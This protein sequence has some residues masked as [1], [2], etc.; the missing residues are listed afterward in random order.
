M[1]LAR[2]H[3]DDPTCKNGAPRRVAA[4]ANKNETTW[5]W[6]VEKEG[7]IGTITYISH[8]LFNL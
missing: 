1:E 8:W 4:T 7:G 2:D 6:K 3:S 5:I